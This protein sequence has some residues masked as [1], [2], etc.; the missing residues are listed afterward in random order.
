MWGI[1]FLAPT[2]RQSCN[3]LYPWFLPFLNMRKPFFFTVKK[4]LRSNHKV[5]WEHQPSTSMLELWCSSAVECLPSVHEA[6]GLIHSTEKK[7]SLL[8]VEKFFR[9]HLYFIIHSAHRE[10]VYSDYVYIYIYTLTCIWDIYMYV[11]IR[12][13]VCGMQKAAAVS[14]SSARSPQKELLIDSNYWKFLHLKQRK[15]IIDFYRSP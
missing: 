3:A 7:K 12:V 5:D 10:H 2:Q 14:F 1:K 4:F 11:Y 15:R 13:C 6:Q 9:M 8:W